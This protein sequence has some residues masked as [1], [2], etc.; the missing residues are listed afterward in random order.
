VTDPPRELVEW[1][2]G[3]DPAIQDLALGLRRVVLEEMAPCHEYIFAMRAKVVLLYG[4]TEHVV[5]DG[6]CL[7]GVFRKQVNLHFKRGVDLRDDRGVLRGSGKGMRHLTLTTLSELDQPHIRAYLREARTN[8]GLRRS[9]RPTPDDVVT[10]V[11]APSPARGRAG[12]RTRRRSDWNQFG[13]P[14]GRTRS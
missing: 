13:M 1:L 4:P 7:V 14:P 12:K 9:R 10:R 2:H 5:R 6:V 3:Y 11:K 8:A